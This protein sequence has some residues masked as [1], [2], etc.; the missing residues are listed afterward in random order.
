M[1]ISSVSPA[2]TT[3]HVPPGVSPDGPWAGEKDI[4]VQA[5]RRYSRRRGWGALLA[6]GAM[7]A[8]GWFAT[9]AAQTLPGASAGG[10][11][12][13]PAV[14]TASPGVAEVQVQ[15]YLRVV[16]D[17]RAGTITLE[18]SM[19]TFQRPD[20]TGPRVMLA[21]AVHIGDASY[22]ATCQELL[23]R[24]DLVLFEGVKPPGARAIAAE[25]SDEEKARA[26]RRRL[27]F[28]GLMAE[29]FREAHARF[30]AD[31]AELRGWKDDRFGAILSAMMTDGWGRDIL[32]RQ[33]RPEAGDAAEAPDAPGKPSEPP[34]IELVSFGADGRAGGEGVAADLV[35][36]VRAPR[37]ARGQEPGL[38]KRMAEALGLAFQLDAID[39]RRP[40]WR[41]SDMSVDEIQERVAAA[42]G[43]ASSLLSMLDGSSIMGRLA[44]M[45]MNLIG[46]SKS[47]A[48]M[49]KLMMVEVLGSADRMFEGA[50][51]GAGGRAAGG[52]GGGP[53]GMMGPLMQVIV[54]DRNEVV[55]NDLRRVIEQEPDK[56]TIALFY[57][58]GHMPDFEARLRREMG[59]V[60]VEEVWLP[61]ITLRLEEMGMTFAEAQRTRQMVA[62]MLRA[63]LGR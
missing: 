2:R 36:V 16:D 6:A 39:T 4:I 47:M 32:V 23:D 37:T 46:S 17:E 31:A 20:G 57:G 14:E 58:A 27:E 48:N 8:A 19:R 25:A 33:V 7:V 53:L 44:G 34:A 28:V 45:M 51:P 26:T 13:A 22:Y 12:P 56:R 10:P 30:P 29:R 49:V 54:K 18:L 50:G 9:A 38:Q 5:G 62:R 24:Q 63:Q 43:D 41:S 11:S 60:P 1:T 15:P 42:G 3:T 52:A 59:L 55:L 35:H 61:A 21:S 40:N